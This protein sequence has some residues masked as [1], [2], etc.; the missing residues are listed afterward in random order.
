[1]DEM[2]SYEGL[3]KAEVLVALYNAAKPQGLG[4]FVS[5]AN[6]MTLEQ[7]E[8][9]L[10]STTKFDYIQGRVLKVDLSN[11]EGFDPWLYDRDNGFSAALNAILDYVVEKRLSSDVSSVTKRND[12]QMNGETLETAIVKHS[13]KIEEKSNIEQEIKEIDKSI[14]NREGSSS[15]PEFKILKW[16]EYSAK[17]PTATT[18]KGTV[19]H[20][21]QFLYVETLK[22]NWISKHIHFV[23]EINKRIE[24]FN[25]V[26][27]ENGME[28]AQLSKIIAYIGV[29]INKNKEVLSDCENFDEV[30]NSVKQQTKELKN[31]KSSVLKQ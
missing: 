5:D 9:L 1:M 26:V 29:F 31:A 14:K 27:A 18:K 30:V 22:Y 15:I 20:K 19:V 3:S 16:A 13:T 10:Q 24:E 6:K 17:H 7:A 4:I 25:K 21:G 23:T 2:V 28:D 12:K 11:D 8:R